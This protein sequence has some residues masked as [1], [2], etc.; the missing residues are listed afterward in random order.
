MKRISYLLLSGVRSEEINVSPQ[1]HIC[2]EDVVEWL[3]EDCGIM[4]EE[5]D[6]RHKVDKYM[7]NTLGVTNGMIY[8]RTKHHAEGGGEA[9]SFCAKIGRKLSGEARLDSKYEHCAC[10]APAGIE[11]DWLCWRCVSKHGHR[12]Y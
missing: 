5:N 11:C 4:V 12:A 2:L 6:I 7:Q 9:R 8:A 1:G 10:A 3:T